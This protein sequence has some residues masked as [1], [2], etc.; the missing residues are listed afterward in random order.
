MYRWGR[1][2]DRIRHS[3]KLEEEKT[4][5]DKIRQAYAISF[6]DRE[7]KAEEEA[8]RR[9]GI[10]PHCHMQIPLNGKCPCQD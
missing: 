4:K 7:L 10:C 3:Y 8:Y 5:D 6:R 2:Y 1:T 9:V